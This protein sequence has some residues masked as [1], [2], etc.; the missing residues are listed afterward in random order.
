MYEYV[1][2]LLLPKVKDTQIFL[3]TRITFATTDFFSPN[4]CAQNKYRS[5]FLWEAQRVE[6]AVQRTDGE[7]NNT[8]KLADLYVST[9]G[10]RE[11]GGE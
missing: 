9:L 5:N 3:K 8:R 2:Y 11:I 4:I 10:I 7:A 6:V 1:C